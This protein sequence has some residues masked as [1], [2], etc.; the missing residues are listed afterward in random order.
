MRSSGFRLLKVAL[1]RIDGSVANF[2]PLTYRYL[3]RASCAVNQ[4]LATICIFLAVFVKLKESKLDARILV[5]ISV[6]SFFIG[7]IIWELLSLDDKENDPNRSTLRTH[8]NAFVF[9][10]DSLRL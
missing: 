9:L 4:H 10:R 3:V 5:W 8:L 6:G 1:T 2:K 7:Y